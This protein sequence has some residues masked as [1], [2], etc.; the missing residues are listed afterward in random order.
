MQVV[1]ADFGVP[2]AVF[3]GSRCRVWGPW[4]RFLHL[5]WPRADFVMSHHVRWLKK[6]CRP[7]VL[8]TATPTPWPG[9]SLYGVGAPIKKSTL[10][11]VREVGGFTPSFSALPR[12]GSL[13]RG[14]EHLGLSSSL[15]P[16]LFRVPG[17]GA[18]SGSSAFSALSFEPRG[19]PLTENLCPGPGTRDIRSLTA[20]PMAWRT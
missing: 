13:G 4:C 10:L 20:L 19:S 9:R 16:F 15:V 1:V 8:T 6:E 2:C 17:T 12:P 18:R 5:L 7:M 14:S 11:L 3:A